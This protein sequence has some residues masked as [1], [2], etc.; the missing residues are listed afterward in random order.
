MAKKCLKLMCG[1]YKLKGLLVGRKNCKLPKEC[2]GMVETTDF[3]SQSELIES[4]QKS[5]FIFLPNQSDASPRI[6]TE[7]LCCGI[8]A[9]VN[10][11]ILGGW[12]YISEKSGEFFTS[13]KD[14]E[15]V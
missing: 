13:E 1:K 11:N 7:A 10:Y 6:L 4:Y 5:K 15:M 12:K 14:T 2:D 9:L 3:L 8:P